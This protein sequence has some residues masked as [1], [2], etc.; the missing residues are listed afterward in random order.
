MPLPEDMEIKQGGGGFSPFEEEVP[1][2][3][4]HGTIIDFAPCQKEVYQKPNE[5]EPGVQMD[6][7]FK[8]MS[9]QLINYSEKMTPSSD[10]R[11]KLRKYLEQL[12]PAELTSE[13]LG[14]PKQ[15]IAL[16]NS[17]IGRPVTMIVGLKPSKADPSKKYST[18]NAIT[19]GT[20]E[21]SQGTSLG[22]IA[23]NETK[24]DDDDI[25]F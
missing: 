2:G 7:C 23:S 22:K 11:A 10:V 9:G 21:A 18:L 17:L 3:T 16:T 25:P 12:C 19:P 5:F 8:G 24:F 15:Y 14:D 4:Y 20:E 13:V 1:P 6:I